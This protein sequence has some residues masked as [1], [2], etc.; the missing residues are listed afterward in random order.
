MGTSGDGASVEHQ[1]LF[2]IRP[3]FSGSS[4]F[5][6]CLLS[7]G[8]KTAWLWCAFGIGLQGLDS[9]VEQ[10]CSRSRAKPIDEIAYGK[11]LAVMQLVIDALT[12][13]IAITSFFQRCSSF[14]ICLESRY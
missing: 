13:Y 14:W 6:V 12:L 7:C 9:I 2:T 3:R 8:N 1:N 11:R 4:G 10:F 5:T